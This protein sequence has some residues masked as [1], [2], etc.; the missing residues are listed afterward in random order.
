MKCKNCI[1][2]EV[3]PYHIDEETTM[4]VT[5]CGRFKHKDQFTELP[6]YIGQKV[7]LTYCRKPQPNFNLKGRAEVREGKISMLQQKADKSWK[8]RVSEGGSVCDYTPDDIGKSIFLSEEPAI[9]KVEAYKKE[10]GIKDAC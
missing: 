4:T 6:Y 2:Y 3:C 1:H 8:F 5:E 10:F 9:L 7:W